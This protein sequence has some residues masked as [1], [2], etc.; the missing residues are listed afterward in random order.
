MANSESRRSRASRN[1]PGAS[2]SSRFRAD[3]PTTFAATPQVTS[4]A[5]ILSVVDRATSAN[6]REPNLALNLQ[7]ADLV[8]EKKGTAPREVAMHLAKLVNSWSMQVALLALSVLDICVKNCGYPFHLAISRRDFLNLLVKRFPERPP[9][10]YTRV[11]VLILEMIEE[12]TATLAK[13]SKYRDDLGHIRDMHRLLSCKGYMFPEADPSEL[14]ALAPDSDALKSAAELER[15]DREVQSAKLQEL[16]RSGTPQDL[17]EANRLMSIMSGFRDPSIDYKARTAAEIDKVR[18]KAD[19]LHEMQVAVPDE[20]SE[21]KDELTQELRGA[22]PKLRRIYAD[23]E[24]SD[25]A[26]AD[27]LARIQEVIRHV[28]EV[29]GLEP[30]SLPSTGA[31]SKASAKATQ[32]SND[33]LIDIFDSVAENANSAA[34][35]AQATAAS[36]GSGASAF[37]G[38]QPSADLT[39]L[40]GLNSLSL[41]DNPE[42]EH[43]IS[44]P[45]DFS[46]TPSPGPESA[47]AS[48]AAASAAQGVAYTSPELEIKYAVA[49]RQDETEITFTVSNPSAKKVTSLVMQ[50]SRPKS[51]TIDVRPATGSELES[52]RTLQQTVVLRGPGKPKLKWMVSFNSGISQLTA[53]GDLTDL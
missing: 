22:L 43:S 51:L 5:Q 35:T 26:D 50:F 24:A 46:A 19:V 7:I 28:E 20:R 29:C 45:L 47:A 34:A 30:S 38:S 2:Y 37:G 31:G 41:T 13:S 27:G 39:D 8:N 9:L 36:S 52:H 32:A 1:A 11:Q 33:L 14:A 17:K 18:R 12:W 21:L 49:K 42:P 3:V 6:L 48:P 23:E 25:D 16:I 40:L 44:L 10:R 4:V 53:K 15:E